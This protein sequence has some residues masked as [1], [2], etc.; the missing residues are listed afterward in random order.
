[1]ILG[2]DPGAQYQSLKEEIDAAV[3]KILSSGYYILGPETAAFEEEFASYTGV[4]HCIGVGNGTDAIHI[5]LKACGIGPGDE[6][7]TVSHTAVATISAILLTGAS[8]VFA[9]ISPASYTLD[10]GHLES[11]VTENTRAIIPVH[12]YG[13]PANMPGIMSLAQKAGV[14]VI[15]DCA[16]AHGALINGQK[17]G[18]FGDLACFSFYPTKNLG[19]MGDG[20]A[21][22]SNN[23]ELAKNVRLLREYGWE[24]KFISRINGFNTRLDEL[25]AAV[26]RVKLQHLDAFNNSR[27]DIAEIYKAELA[28]L[29]IDLPTQARN[30]EHVYHLFVVRTDQRDALKTYLQQRDIQAGVHY[31]LP[32]H[33]QQPYRV[34]GL[35]LEQTEYVCKHI[36]SLPMYPELGDKLVDVVDAVKSFYAG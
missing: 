33:L 27:R 23:P 12:L 18:T 31:P 29:A 15:E 17:V 1:M 14:Y 13:H 9:D 6:V 34:E 4:S 36:L 7:I 19:A 11:L 35:K 24:E 28:D 25:Q 5:A 2:S 20:G 8:P 30:C 26:L 16:Q 21:V 22:V 32:V 10:P 3:N